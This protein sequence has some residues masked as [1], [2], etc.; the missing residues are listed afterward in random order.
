MDRSTI[1]KRTDEPE[2]RQS[3]SVQPPVVYASD[4]GSQG[5]DSV[6]GTWCSEG[7]AG[8]HFRTKAQRTGALNPPPIGPRL[9]RIAEQAQQYPEMKFYTLAHHLDV[10]VLERAFWSL[11]PNSA[12]GV[13][14][15]TWHQYQRDL[16]TNLAILHERLVNRTYQPQPVVRCWILK[17]DGK[18]FRPLGIPA[19][20]DK[21]VSKAVAMLLE[22]IYEQDFYDFSYGFRPG[23]SC[24]QASHDLRQGLL[25]NGIQY[26]IDC[27]IRAFFDNLQHDELIAILRERVTDGRVLELIEMWLKAGILDDRELVF[28]EK[29]SPQGSVISPLLAN[30]YLHEVLDKW[31]AE[32][33]T[34]HCRGKVMLIRYADDFIIGCRHEEDARRIMDVLPKRFARYGLEVNQEK[35]KLVNFTRPPYDHGLKGS[36]SKRE[37]PGTFSFLGFVYYWGKTY[38]GSHT[39]KR[40]TEGK[41]LRRSMQAIWSWC[42]DNRHRPIEDQYRILSAKL[43]GHYQYYGVR[44]NSRCLDLVY[45]TARRAWRYWLNRRG[46]RKKN[47]QGFGKM[48]AKLSLPRPRIVQAWV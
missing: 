31:F 7:E 20:V 13:D 4:P 18:Q 43:R 42:R 33:V 8:R 5:T 19:L 39:I 17:G 25:K 11:K 26:V 9:A 34:R 16:E 41:R 30:A 10:A 12:A 36:D 3:Q 24:H 47:W 45:Y 22:Q 37:K 27:D 44:C 32:V 15:I 48:M 14:R 29:G 1:T 21:I 40:K 28:P 6:R 46:G 23:R 38:R 35:T 2:I